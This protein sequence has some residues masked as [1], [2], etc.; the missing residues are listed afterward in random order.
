MLYD[1]FVKDDIEVLPCILKI[2]A[3][4]FKYG[5]NRKNCVKFT[6]KEK[7]YFKDF[8]N[9]DAFC[10]LTGK[11]SK[12]LEC[13]DFDQKAIMFEKWKS[14]IP[15]SIF[16][17]LYLEST[18]KGG[19]HVIYHCDEQV[20][21]NSKLAYNEG[22]ICIE[23][24]GEGGLVV[25]Y[26]TSSYSTLQGDI[27]NIATITKA[28][29]DLLIESSKKL[30]EKEIVVRER[31][32][33]QVER[34]DDQA[35][36]EIYE[37]DPITDFNNKFDVISYLIKK[38]WSISH[39]TSSCTYFTRPLKD[40]GISASWNGATFYV[41]TT[42]TDL[43]SE[44]AYNAYQIYSVYEDDGDLKKTFK[45]LVAD[46]FGKLRKVDFD[47]SILKNLKGA[48]NERF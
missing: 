10:I 8:Y 27:M 48:R 23:T 16:D 18:L 38:G 26:P 14:L 19:L 42:N 11:I 30:N 24:R 32:V 43:D 35:F 4:P 29:R 36:S 12:N 44:R 39:E 3:P 13:I 33:R 9:T 40:D 28:E 15:S 22:G 41:F 7:K 17:K 34:F 46:G 5:E 47:M 1:L 37:I 6:F 31:P 45:R 21:G 25:T 2:K 20:D